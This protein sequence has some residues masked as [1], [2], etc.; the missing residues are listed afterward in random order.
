[1]K[2]DE[3]HNTF[4]ILIFCLF[5]LQVIQAQSSIK[6]QK[7]ENG[8]VDHWYH[9]K[10]QHT[11]FQV[12]I[13]NI[14]NV[15]WPEKQ[16]PFGYSVALLTGV[17][18]YKHLTPDLPSVEN[19][20]QDMREFLLQTGGFDEVFVIKNGNLN[21]D[22]VERYIKDEL[23][24]RVGKDGRLLFYF[25][26]HGADKTGSNTGYMQFSK[27]EADK[28]FGN[29]VLAVNSVETWSN[30]VEVKHLLV[31]LDCC[32]SGLAFTG[33]GDQACDRAI[34]N[35]LSGNGSRT[36]LTAG[37]ADQKT[38]ALQARKG[39]RNGVFTRA[40][41]DAFEEESAGKCGL[42]TIHEIFSQLYRDVSYFS[43]KS[44]K[45]V[46]PRMW[47]LDEKEFKG[48]FVFI[49][50]GI[51]NLTFTDEQI[52][53]GRLIKKSGMPEGAKYGTI[54]IISQY[55]G[56]VY[57]D[58]N[59][60]GT[61]KANIAL[62]LYPVRV[63]QHQV[64]I[65]GTRDS[66]TQTI[67]LA[68]NQTKQVLFLSKVVAKEPIPVDIPKA[69]P[70]RS[71][72]VEDLSYE[73][74]KKMLANH[75]FFDRDWN[76]DGKGYA[77][78]F[79]PVTRK[80]KKLVVDEKSGLTWQESGSSQYMPFEQAPAYIQKLRREKY[81]GYSDWRLPTLE[82]AMSLM[83]PENMNGDLYIDPVFD[84][85]QA[86]IWTSDRSSASSAWV[87][88]FS[89]GGCGGSGVRAVR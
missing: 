44:R 2:L 16:A 67:D 18:D 4:R 26:G 36:V 55:D 23:P 46:T 7:L 86:W 39:K 11:W 40:F 14:S 45:E 80:G 19:D 82:E 27:A 53:K 88:A 56:T 58:G 76:K 20:L 77:N 22:I 68:H 33:K 62:P 87:V 50:P 5:P 17:S 54:E 1:M 31:L 60:R 63:G 84:K 66:G 43:K 85:K 69:M 42:F 32:S 41:L 6:Y 83:E 52:E 74:V 79:K 34:I 35:T 81:G 70:F 10:S 65:L 89:Y 47:P 38:Y 78:Q 49:N 8:K 75:D 72:P 28:F 21:R 13:E 61:A 57:L 64:K 12:Q 73:A 15:L 48:T 3:L 29:E 24:K 9:P 30:E 37:T 51:K 59:A 71:T 25:S